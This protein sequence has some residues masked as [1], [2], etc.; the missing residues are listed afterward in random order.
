MLPPMYRDSEGGWRGAPRGA[1]WTFQV[2]Q[3]LRAHCLA[4]GDIPLPMPKGTEVQAYEH[5]ELSAHEGW[6]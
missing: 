2:G 3:F 1:E 4:A 5:L 6:R